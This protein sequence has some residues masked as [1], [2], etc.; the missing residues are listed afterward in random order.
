[1]NRTIVVV[2]AHKVIMLQTLDSKDFYEWLYAISP[3]LVGQIR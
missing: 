2:T 3:L 1:M